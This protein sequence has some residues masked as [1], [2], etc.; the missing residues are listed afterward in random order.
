MIKAL[1]LLCVV[2]VVAMIIGKP[3]EADASSDVD[4]KWEYEASSDIQWLD[5]WEDGFSTG[6]LNGDGI[7]D[8]V[9][10]TLSGQVVALD[11]SNGRELWP[12]VAIPDTTGPV[13]ADIINRYSRRRESYLRNG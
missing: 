5:H 13:N 6:D 9:F 11:G 3:P 12:P 10:G 4:V 2:L 8:V 1:K 7:P